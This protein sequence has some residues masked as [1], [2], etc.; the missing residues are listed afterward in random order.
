MVSG[1]G[2]HMVTSM[3]WV[4]S[5]NLVGSLEKFVGGP[6]VWL[7]GCCFGLAENSCL[8]SGCTDGG[9]E[10]DSQGERNSAPLPCLPRTSLTWTVLH[11]CDEN[12]IDLMRDY[13]EA[14][15]FI[16]EKIT[17][18]PGRLSCYINN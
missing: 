4:L 13:P 11:S 9:E 3:R 7:R 15:D 6:V 10:T 2:N 17:H 18:T 8:Q 16:N 5:G 12:I 14:Y 1:Q